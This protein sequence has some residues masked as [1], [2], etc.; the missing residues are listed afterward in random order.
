VTGAPE[1]LVGQAE[2][3]LGRRVVRARQA[4]GGYTAAE[5]WVLGFA[6][7]SS[8]F[9]K[10]A[11]TEQ[12][13]AWLRTEHRFYSEIG[14]EFAPRLFGW[15]DPGQQPLLLLEDLSRADWPPPWTAERIAAVQAILGR[16]AAA[17]VPAWAPPL[18]SFRDHFSG[19]RR[20]A[21][22]PAPF[23]SLQLVMPVWLER[24]LPALLEAEAGAPLEGDALVHL[25]VRSDNLCFDGDRVVL[26]D[27]NWLSRG[28]S[29][30]DLAGWLPTLHAEGGPGPW[31]LCADSRGYAAMLAGLWASLAGLP[32]PA[33]APRVRAVQLQALRSALPWAARE[34]GLPPLDA[35]AAPR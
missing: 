7:G 10:M 17:P 4:E 11:T 14:P 35:V 18:A 13:A 8:A 3:V 15:Y 2:A 19:W 9:A 31:E 1:A 20:V 25:D 12:T 28:D 6:D 29:L 21:A 30:F 23:L 24:A 22:D 33:G 34:L 16:V 5:R 26:V 32:P 27:W